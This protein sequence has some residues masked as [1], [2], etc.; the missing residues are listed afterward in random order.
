M[1]KIIFAL[2]MLAFA[3]SAVPQARAA[4][5]SIDFIYDNLSG[6]NWIDVGGYGYG[7]QPDIAT[8]DPNWRPYTDGYWAYTD[9][10][11][12]WISYEDFGWATYHYGRWANLDD[13]GWTW[14]PGSDLDWGPAWVS[15]RTGG[16]YIGWAP[17]PPRGPEVVYESQPIGANV[18]VVFNI[19]PEYYNFCDV[20]F[21]GE[22]VLR[23]RILPPV[24]NVTYI[25][26][27][28]NVTNIMVQNNVVYNYGPDFNTV[29]TYSSR[30]IQQ[31]AIQRETAG[32]LSA[33]VRSGTLTKVQGNKLLVAAPS[34]LVKAAPAAKPP[35][36][37]ARVA[38]PK[39]E[40]GWKGVS[41]RAEL[42]QKMKTENPKNVPP[43]TRAAAREGGKPRPAPEMSPAGPAGGAAMSPGP[44]GRPGRIAPGGTAAPSLGASPFERG[45]GR[46]GGRPQPGGTPVTEQGE[47]RVSPAP[48]EGGKPG[49]RGRPGMTPPTTGP[50]EGLSPA[51]F[52]RGQPRGRGRPG[53]T[54]PPSGPRE[55]LSP[56]PFERGQGRV[57]P[58]ERSS[59]PGAAGRGPGAE[60]PTPPS[61]LQSAP[62]QP[63]HG[64]PPRQKMGEA[65]TSGE[66]EPER[67]PP[68]GRGR[69]TQPEQF[70][71]PPAKGAGEHRQRGEGQQPGFRQQ[72]TPPT[73][74]GSAEAGRAQRERMQGAQNQPPAQQQQQQQQQQRGGAHAGAQQHG[75]PQP[76][77]G[78]KK[79][80][81][82]TPPPGPQ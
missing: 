64:R 78:Q 2:S 76:E 35:T 56:A 75:Q 47:G 3:V 7:W 8:S 11:W 14:F 51:P 23:D 6:G 21:I 4:D 41:N 20:R 28:V 30:P 71:T 12:T 31:L 59:E 66:G 26:N 38:Q 46:I 10:G 43:P 32:N 68:Q 27:T 82:G 16:D 62:S 80:E 34:R 9:Y 54:A 22:P 45:K 13:Y 49:G 53:M 72:V 79:H 65:P 60:K 77:G 42:E 29:N 50:R 73:G 63:E 52:E 40:H 15:W 5:I 74:E 61:A 67:V 37:K 18:D 36:V 33:A 44:R 25:T 70:N 48:F 24:Q 19:G 57:K 1:K 69:G 58:G 17:L 39:I 81:R 55:G